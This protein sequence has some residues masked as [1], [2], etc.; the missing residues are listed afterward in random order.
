MCCVGAGI[1]VW[2]RWGERAETAT[3]Q[4]TPS[5]TRNATPQ[6]EKSERIKQLS[7]QINATNQERLSS[8]SSSRG[9]GGPNGVPAG[10]P[11][12]RAGGGSGGGGGG[13]GGVGVGSLASLLPELRR[14]APSY[15]DPS[16]RER[17]VEYAKSSV[18]RPEPAR[19]KPRSPPGEGGTRGGAGGRGGGGGGG[20]AGRG[21]G[22]LDRLQQQHEADSH[23]VEAIRRELERSLVRGVV[24]FGGG[25]VL[26]VRGLWTGSGGEPGRAC[27]FSG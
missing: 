2:R 17:A 13:S 11:S 15:K 25:R 6:R 5:I 22:R 8:S 24:F 1:V 20:A 9:L 4:A 27:A 12:A 10:G 7:R 3:N 16:A 19:K 14:R 26:F 23:A 21:D 18:P